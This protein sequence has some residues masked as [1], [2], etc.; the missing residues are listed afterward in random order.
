M[1]PTN[2]LVDRVF[3]FCEYLSNKKLFPYQAQFAK[4]IIRSLL[5]NDGAEITGLM[6]RQSGK[7]ETVAC[8]ASGC[9]VILPILAN[10]PM[11][12]DDKRL[13]VYRNGVLMGLFAPALHQAQI[14]FNRIKDNVSSDHALEVLL[15]PDI[16]VIMDTNN[17][18]N[19]VLRFRN[20][21]ISSTITCMSASDQSNIEGKSYMLVICDESQDISNYK[22]LKSISPMVAFY[23]GTRVLIGTPTISRGF[24]YESIEINKKEYAAG[25]RARNH[26]EYDYR[27]VC[28]YNPNYQKHVEEQLRKLGEKSD[29]FQM[30]YALKWILERG[31]FVDM[32]TF[33]DLAD[34]MRG[35]VEYDV[36]NPH[37]AGIDLG[38][39]LD[40]TVATIMQVDLDNPIMIEKSSDS[41]VDD[42]IVYEGFIKNWLEIEGDNWNK[43]HDTLRAFLSNYKLVRAVMDAT[44]VGNPVYDRLAAVSDFELLP[45]VFS[46]QSKSAL[47]KH[48]DSQI[49]GRRMFYPADE[50]TRETQ[51]YQRFVQQHLILEKSYSG[52]NMVCAA[53]KEKG[54]H[55]DYPVSAALANW[56]LKGDILRPGTERYNPFISLH[57]RGYNNSR[58]RLTAKRVGRG[59]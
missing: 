25:Q 42:Y 53:P 14:I 16:N 18:Q 35:L 46:T 39:N 3:A 21:A 45:F 41:E 17:G 43:Q 22:Y 51:E 52:Q 48:Y 1:I 32:E 13:Q 40:S 55:D 56:A 9:A 12:L 23:N 34:V 20:L 30:S 26:F 47:F 31:M 38:K 29:M 27:Y 36:T 58:N 11:Y 24:F 44:G 15:D 10:M 7:S 54:A 19:V 49:K 33:E 5:E 57:D 37:V 59:F 50:I 6:S 4:R 8:V 28:R 2:A